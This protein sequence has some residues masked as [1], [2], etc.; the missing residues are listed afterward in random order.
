MSTTTL[1]A[2][3]GAD[4]TPASLGNATLIL[5]DYQNVYTGG[6]MEL[7]GWK[8]A[9]EAASGLLAAARRAGATVIHVQEAG[10]DVESEAGR[11][12]ESVAPVEGEAVVVKNVPNGFHGT[13][14]GAHVDAAGND[15]VVIAGFMTHMCVLFTTEGA[16]LRGNRPTVVADACAT[17][18]LRTMHAGGTSL[19]ARQ[20]HDGAL[21]TITDRYGVVVPSLAELR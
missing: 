15:D 2:L 18:P 3:T 16:S 1:R 21:A 19:T 11:I 8:P 14:L 10:Y 9:L 17:R 7:D 12:H 13:D 5:V 20:L 4:E 6:V